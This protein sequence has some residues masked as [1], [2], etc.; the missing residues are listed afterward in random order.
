MRAVEIGG[1][2]TA[3]RCERTI[4]LL[5][6]FAHPCTNN[7]APVGMISMCS[8]LWRRRVTVFSSVSEIRVGAH[9][10]PD[11]RRSVMSDVFIYTARGKVD[12]VT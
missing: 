11:G 6:L 8:D 3:V 10:P 4:S 2:P 5:L 1:I 9:T 7:V 12:K